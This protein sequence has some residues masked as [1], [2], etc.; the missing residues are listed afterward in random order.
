VCLFIRGKPS[1]FTRYSAD[2]ARNI[3]WQLPRDSSTG[4][5]KRG[6]KNS[7]ESAAIKLPRFIIR[8]TCVVRFQSR[9]YIP[10]SLFFSRIHFLL[11][12]KNQIEFLQL[13]FSVLKVSLL[14]TPTNIFKNIL[15]QVRHAFLTHEARFYLIYHKSPLRQNEAK[16][17][18]SFYAP[19]DDTARS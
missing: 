16:S 3:C 11:S 10:S 6:K 18:R 15:H 12:L 14:R 17:K 2:A 4:E 5:R 19:C 1:S 7:E 8:G 9:Q 13:H